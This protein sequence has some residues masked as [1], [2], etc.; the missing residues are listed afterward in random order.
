MLARIIPRLLLV[1]LFTYL[2]AVGATF[3]G[4]LTLVDTQPLTLTLFGLCVALWFVAHLRR[5]WRWH[6]SAFD[7]IFLLWG[8]AI[9]LS[10]LANPHTW[11][12]SAEA[13]WYVLLYIGV[14]YLLYDV[15][16]N[17][18]LNLDAIIDALLIVGFVILLLGYWQTVLAMQRGLGIPRPVSTLGNY[19]YL[20]AFI[21]MLAPFAL[22]RALQAKNVFARAA[23]K[24]YLLLALLLLLLTT[25]RGAW[26]GMGAAFA[27]FGI[28]WLAQRDLLRIAKLRAWWMQ[29]PQ[30]TRR[31]LT[32]GIGVVCI[33]TV[34]VVMAFFYIFTIGGRGAQWRTLV[35]QAALEQFSASPL[36][37][38]G[39]FTYGYHLPTFWSIPPQ[40]P[41]AHAHSIPF[42]VLAELGLLGFGV[43]LLSAGVTLW[44][45][46]RKW[47]ALKAAERLPFI[48]ITTALIGFGTHNLFDTP[49]MMPLITLMGLLLFVLAIVP[50]NPQ[51][52][53]A[54][55]R[56]RGHPI[57]IAGLWVALL[58][59][60]FWHANLYGYYFRT[61]ETTLDGENYAQAAQALDGWIA[62]D[63]RQ[64][65]YPMQQGLLWGLAAA[66]GDVEAARAAIASYAYYLA[67]E[68]NQAPAWANLAALYWQSG[69]AA[70]ASASIA[71]ARRLAPDW[72][73]FARNARVYSAE[74]SA[75]DVVP[76]ASIEGWYLN[77]ARF[78][79]LREGLNIEYIPQVG[80][81]G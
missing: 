13:I 7:L 80:W 79:Y 73:H 76:P 66:Q 70:A 34:G 18:G 75:E 77:M 24:I 60:G 36:V 49:A 63:P 56:V 39:L 81:G 12:R 26:V 22:L 27:L 5:G 25:S 62:A 61:L 11:R 28:M 46:W 20:G 8:G 57:G 41:H 78:Q 6:T 10:V 68:P 1:L 74:I 55:W 64:P 43:L 9:A 21:V 31:R 58:L 59:V 42:N 54:N 4:L 32:V 47:R 29:Q 71:E 38:N 67:L 2:A 51:P 48:A 72:P 40:Q 19:N 52:M 15:L 16:S 50:V 3:N 17:N 69:D 23:M 30:R 33:A 14:F 37:G 53:R 65:M 35:W 45:L 44:L